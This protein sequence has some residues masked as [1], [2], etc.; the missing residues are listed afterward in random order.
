MAQQAMGHVM[1]VLCTVGKKH[2]K[3]RVLCL[4]NTALSRKKRKD[5]GFFLFAVFFVC[6]C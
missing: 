1:A 6:V 2:L 5:R 4:E 3:L